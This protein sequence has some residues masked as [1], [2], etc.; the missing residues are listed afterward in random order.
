M[1]TP[2]CD[3]FLLL[4]QQATTPEKLPPPEKAAVYMALIAILLLGML[5]I[6]II[7]L[8]GHWVRRWGSHRRGP[9]V[10]ADMIVNSEKTASTKQA[11]NPPNNDISSNDT[12]RPDDTI[13][14]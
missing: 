12:V 7:L 8:G 9:A 4:A 1:V 11:D 6:V 2:L 10:P 14:S 13:V 3:N 5:L